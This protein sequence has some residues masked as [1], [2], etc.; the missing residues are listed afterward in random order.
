MKVKGR[1]SGEC[2]RQQELGTNGRWGAASEEA[3]LRWG[4]S[5]SGNS[6]R[7][8]QGSGGVSG[9]NQATSC[10]GQ[11]GF[12]W[13]SVGLSRE[14]QEHQGRQSRLGKPLL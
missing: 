5:V 6:G 11:V 10:E 8:E 13:E 4:V 3:Q 12:T 2:Q 1:G 9:G 14:D 7:S